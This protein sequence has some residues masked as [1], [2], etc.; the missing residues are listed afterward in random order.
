MVAASTMSSQPLL[1]VSISLSN[2]GL[3]LIIMVVDD[4]GAQEAGAGLQL[5]PKR[6]AYRSAP[7]SH[8]HSHGGGSYLLMTPCS[9]T[10]FEIKELEVFVD[11]Y[12]EIKKE[13]AEMLLDK[14]R[15]KSR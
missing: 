4:T 13:K 6:Y 7:H 14:V 11:I 5:L 10:I 12:V 1:A 3:A 9:H 8:S 2:N 15:W